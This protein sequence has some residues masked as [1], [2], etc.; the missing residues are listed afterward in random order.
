LASSRPVLTVIAGPNG[1]GK[2]TITAGLT[3]KGRYINADDIKRLSHC[4]DLEAA[5][6]AEKLREYYLDKKQD[7]AFET[8]LSTERNLNLIKR[9]K[10]AGYYIVSYFILTADAELNVL[11]VL[12]RTLEGG[13]SVPPEKIRSRYVKSLLNIPALVKL[14]DEL[15]IMDNTEEPNVI[16]IKNNDKVSVFP[17]DFW[18]ESKIKK[19]T[20]GG[21]Y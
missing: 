4:S 19:L 2:T 17:N 15:I 6:E 5:E 10:E 7:F 8:V 18:S 9:A 13:H 21:K 16:F 11:R 14:S 1:S 3:F 20:A 12:S